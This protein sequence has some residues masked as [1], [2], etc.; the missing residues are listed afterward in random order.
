MLARRTRCGL[1]L[2][3]LISGLSGVP[4]SATVARIA[5][6]PGVSRLARRA[7]S[8]RRPRIS[9]LSGLPRLSLRSCRTRRRRGRWSLITPRNQQ[10]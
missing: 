10:H 8:A 9:L 5:R 7:C 2:L 1:S 3:A 6:L 4:C